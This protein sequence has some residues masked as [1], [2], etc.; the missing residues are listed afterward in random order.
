M[1]SKSDTQ[2]LRSEEPPLWRRFARRIR[3]AVVPDGI[4]NS[5]APESI[6]L[7]AEIPAG[8]DWRWYVGSYTDLAPAGISDE[9]SAVRH[10]L[11]HGC[12]EGRR[13]APRRPNSFDWLTYVDRFPE[14]PSPLRLPA[15]AR[16]RLACPSIDSIFLRAWGDLVCWDDA[17]S[18]HVLQKWDPAKDYGAAFLDGPYQDVRQL[19]AAGR[20]AWPEICTRCVLLRMQPPDTGSW[21]RSFVRMLRV[22]PSY[23][24]S[25]DCPGCVP[26]SVRRGHTEGSQL[27]PDI[28]DRIIADLVVHGL[29]VDVVDFQGHGE[30][31]LNPRL[32]EMSRRTRDQLPKAWISVTTNAQ[33]RFRREMCESGLN[34]VVCSIDGID[35]P[36]YAPYRVHG[37]FDLAWRLMTDLI[38]AGAAA[39]T[40]LRVV[41]KYVLFEHNSAPEMLLR[42]QQMALDAGVRE[43]VFVLTRSGP[44]PRHI[45]QPD[46]VPRLSTALP[47]SFR[48]FNASIDDLEAR[49]AESQRLVAGGRLGEAEELRDSIRRNIERFY[50][51]PAEM[52]DRHGHLLQK[53]QE[54]DGESGGSVQE[55]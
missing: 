55:S 17:G 28:L 42:A 43:L 26:L 20:M 37:R 53:V 50:S 39:A 6:R 45:V 52:P 22:E 11:E 49:F 24:C 44:A 33:A 51:S 30:P 5:A 15:E 31:L 32:F 12:R 2:T 47:V 27:D 23:Y 7:E 29:A 1:S 19:S 34:E 54:K 46:D 14:S 3:R 9:A 38:E 16:P 41:W 4:E 40:P 8:F 13:F 10:W 21:D 25:L 36:S 48:F 35:Q 18:D